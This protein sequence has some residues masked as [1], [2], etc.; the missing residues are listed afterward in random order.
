M[1]IKCK[2]LT[3]KG[4]EPSKGPYYLLR[5]ERMGVGDMVVQVEA[6][7]RKA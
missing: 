2:K 3:G 5:L 4:M 6:K 1:R 7:W